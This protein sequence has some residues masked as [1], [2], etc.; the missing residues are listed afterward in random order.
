MGGVETGQLLKCLSYKQE[1][2]EFDPPN[3]IKGHAR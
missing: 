1:D 2:L 3:H